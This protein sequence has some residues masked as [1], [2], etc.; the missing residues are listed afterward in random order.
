ME[1]GS[2]TLYILSSDIPAALNTVK[3][4]GKERR[5]CLFCGE[6][7]RIS[8]MRNHVGAHILKAQRGVA[9]FSLIV[10]KE[11]SSFRFHITITITSSTNRDTFLQI[12]INPCG[13]CGKEQCKTRLTE[14]ENSMKITSDCEYHYQNMKYR[15]AMTSTNPNPCTNVPLNCPQ[16]DTFWKYGFISHIADRQLTESIE[17]PILDFPLDLWVMTH[18]SKW[19]EFKF[20]IPTFKD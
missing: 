7:F 19:E 4:A 17:L 18:I 13:W 3:L 1:D 10:G 2:P 11:V 14:S 20:G 8:E 6:T 16:S 9:D 5:P 12:G 15:N